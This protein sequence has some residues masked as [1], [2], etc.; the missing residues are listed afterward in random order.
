MTPIKF[1]YVSI[2]SAG[3]KNWF[4]LSSDVRIIVCR[5][6]KVFVEIIQLSI[7]NIIFKFSYRG[8]MNET[9]LYEANSWNIKFITRTFFYGHPV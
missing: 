1:F 9:T 5:W 2:E 3:K 6:I 7:G 4:S 8:L